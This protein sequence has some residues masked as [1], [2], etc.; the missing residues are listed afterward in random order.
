MTPT[1]GDFVPRRGPKS[2]NVWG[3]TRCRLRDG[4]I[5]L[6]VLALT[7]CARTRSISA[8]RQYFQPARVE[9]YFEVSLPEVILGVRVG[10]SHNSSGNPPCGD[11]VEIRHSMGAATGC[12]NGNL[13]LVDLLGVSGNAT[14]LP[15][16]S[17]RF[18]GAIRA[19]LSS[20]SKNARFHV[21]ISEDEVFRVN[22]SMR[23]KRCKQGASEVSPSGAAKLSCSEGVWTFE[24][25]HLTLEP[26]GSKR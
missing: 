22:E 8:D 26:I 12:W 5:F 3:S 7:S 9:R 18:D 15:V 19:A 13:F 25:R 1:N 11:Q 6:A 20:G 10:S 23:S 17:S 4:I 2:P 21:Q 24:V 14:M 16:M